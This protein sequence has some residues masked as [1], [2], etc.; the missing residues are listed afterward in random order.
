[1]KLKKKEKIYQGKDLE[2]YLF[3]FHRIETTK[4]VND[5]FDTYDKKK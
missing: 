3:N 1:M 4:L 5:R 2:H